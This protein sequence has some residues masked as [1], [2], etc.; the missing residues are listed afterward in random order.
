MIIMYRTKARLFR[1]FNW[2]VIFCFYFQTLWPTVVFAAEV[3]VMRPVSPSRFFY[4]P[5]APGTMVLEMGITVDERD[6][7]FDTTRKRSTLK[8]PYADTLEE[9]QGL[10]DASTSIQSLYPGLQVSEEGFGWNNFGFSFFLDNANHLWVSEQKGATA[11]SAILR[12]YNPHG[13]VIIEGKVNLT[14]LLAKGAQVFVK[15]CQGQIDHLSLWATD[16]DGIV[17][18]DATSS[19]TVKKATV[20]QGTLHNLGKVSV[21][22]N[23][24]LDAK[25][26]TIANYG[27]LDM[28]DKSTLRA[29]E[30]QNQRV[31]SNPAVSPIIGQLLG[32]GTVTL[33]IGTFR[34]LGDV[35]VGTLQGRIQQLINAGHF[36][37]IRGFNNLVVL[38]LLNDMGGRILGQ[39][40]LTLKGL[41]KGLIQGQ[42]ITLTLEGELINTEFGTI[43]VVDRLET[44]GTGSFLQRGRLDATHFTINN[45]RFENFAEWLQDQMSVVIGKNVT[46]WHNHEDAKLKAKQVVVESSSHAS[47]LL[48]EGNLEADEFTNHR[49]TFR[50][51][52]TL[53]FKRWHQFGHSFNN[54]KGGE[55]RVLESFQATMDTLDNEGDIHFD[56][57]S[58][59]D[60][61]HILNSGGLFF[62]GKTSLKGST[63]HNKKL[64]RAKQ[65]Q[66]FE[67][68][69]DIIENFSDLYL[70]NVNIKRH[71]TNAKT[72]SAQIVRL[73][74]DKLDELENKGVL[75]VTGDLM[76]EVE[77]IDSPGTLVV[78]GKTNIKGKNL[79]T[80]KDSIMSLKGGADLTFTD[81]LT[82]LG[83][84]QLEG[85][86]SLKAP[87]ITNK[88][89]LTHNRG[90]ATIEGTFYHEG[91]ALF[92]KD[93]LEALSVYIRPGGQ[94][95]L[96]EGTHRI[97][98]FVNEGLLQTLTKMKLS[99]ISTSYC[100]GGAIESE[101]GLRVLSL[102]AGQKAQSPE[103]DSPTINLENSPHAKSYHL[104]LTENVRVKGD[105][106]AEFP[107][108]FD[109]AQWWLII[110]S[111]K[112][113]GVL[114]LYGYSFQQ[115]KDITRGG[116]LKLFVKRYQNKKHTFTANALDIEADEFDVGTDNDTL[117]MIQTV[118]DPKIKGPQD[119]HLT[120]TK[121]GRSW[122]D[123]DLRFA[124]V[125]GNG[126]TSLKALAG[127]V[128]IGHYREARNP[129]EDFGGRIFGLLPRGDMT[130][131]T[132]DLLGYLKH[133]GAMYQRDCNADIE[134]RNAG[135]YFAALERFKR[136][137][138]ETFV[139]SNDKITIDAPAGDVILSY[140]NVEAKEELS[141]K[142]KNKVRQ[143]AGSIN[144]PKM[145]L[146][147]QSFE[148]VIDGLGF[149]PS[150]IF[151]SAFFPMSDQ[152]RLETN[153]LT[154][155]FQH[156]LTYGSESIIK[157]SFTYRGKDGRLVKLRPDAPI[158]SETFQELAADC[159]WYD[160]IELP[161]WAGHTYVPLRESIDKPW[162][163]EFKA[164]YYPMHPNNW[165]NF[166]IPSTRHTGK[167]STVVAKKQVSQGYASSG[168]IVMFGQQIFIVGSNGATLRTTPKSGV[169]STY[170]PIQDRIR[171]NGLYQTQADG[172]VRSP[173]FKD[174]AFI[175]PGQ[176]PVWGQSTLGVTPTYRIY[177]EANLVKSA[178]FKLM[179]VHMGRIH[180]EGLYGD[181]LIHNMTRYSQQHAVLG[182][183]TSEERL[184][185]NVSGLAVFYREVIIDGKP[186]AV[187]DFYLPESK[188]NAD[189]G[190]PGLSG[191]DADI[192]A[193]GVHLERVKV[194][195]DHDLNVT[196]TTKSITVAGSELSAG[197]DLT[198]DAEEWIDF[199]SLVQ[200][201][202]DGE[203]YTDHAVTAKAIAGHKLKMTTRQG[204]LRFKGAY[205]RSGVKTRFK[206]GRRIIDE[207]LALESQHVHRHARGWSKDTYTHQQQ[208]EHVTEGVLHSTAEETQELY[209]PKFRA[210]KVK[211]HGKHGVHFYEVHKLHRHESV[212]NSRSG[213]GFLGGSRKSE[214]VTSYNAESIG[215]EVDSLEPAE[216]T[217]GKEGITLTNVKFKTPKTVLTTIDGVVRFLLGTNYSSYTRVA[218]GSSL[219]WQSV[220]QQ[221]EEH[222]T[223]AS[224]SGTGPFEIYSKETIVQGVLGKTNEL[225]SQIEQHGGIV[226]QEMLAEYHRSESFRAGG[227]TAALAAVIA[228]AVTIA[229]QG[230]GTWLGGQVAGAA[231]LTT[232]TSLTTAGTFVA[233]ATTAAFTS[234]CSQAAI[235]VVA[236]KGDIGKA[237]NSLANSN[238]LKS[239]VM[240]AASG[241]LIDSI[242]SGLGIP[243]TAAECATLAD[244]A[245]R[246]V[247]QA[248]VSAGIGIAIGEDGDKVASSAFRGA[249][250]GTIG[251]KLANQ[252]GRAYGEGM[253]DAITHKL[254]HA[255]L[256][257]ATGSIL[258]SDITSGALS[259]AIGAVAAETV[260]DI[261]EEDSDVVVSKALEKAKAEGKPLDRESLTPFVLG[262]LRKTV[263]ISRFSGALATLLAGQDVAVGT[264]A[265]TIAVENNFLGNALKAAFKVLYKSAMKEAAKEGTK[266]GGR[267]ALKKPSTLKWSVSKH[268]VSR[269]IERNIPTSSIIDALK[270][271]LKVGPLKMDN[272]GRHSQRFIGKKA[273][274][275][276][277]P[278]TGKIVSVNRTGSQLVKKLLKEVE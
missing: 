262:E 42:S 2:L 1:S 189:A 267:A 248:S 85:D 114:S 192:V 256:G 147:G 266:Q 167:S 259:G 52:G 138:N 141:I 107:E 130:T 55:I 142:A 28:G 139:A 170:V 154:L 263:E 76:G 129:G 57:E 113:S 233:G 236:N 108:Y 124:K 15:G 220:S 7:A 269:K 36:E 50:N 33:D 17:A 63:I 12:L 88:G 60:I 200:R 128:V 171:N 90:K 265:G 84:V 3:D 222:K 119:N 137:R 5:S 22:E 62:N 122:E 61:L 95:T 221:L 143:V 241:G 271:P 105:F 116:A 64:I 96:G 252:I 32:S 35:R 166:S 178:L 188:V 44:L 176:E 152:P 109:I 194:R 234:L 150:P 210:R 213:G 46:H 275:A 131:E 204:D 238:T 86:L 39:G 132:L 224:T 24:T 82:F 212:S 277:N 98:T 115:D 249:L 6:E 243:T 87:E 45:A 54:L 43:K 237:A 268:G 110:S 274:V 173:Y 196:A 242:S 270:N 53:T 261:I 184:R 257:A 180:D 103:S 112:Q 71:F 245:A 227:P 177:A 118:A 175:P 37:A 193:D 8:I 182:S 244:H 226:T 97:G 145:T 68:T 164:I 205:T 254:M 70:R 251:G 264:A 156:Y 144:A 190:L 201:T 56:G 10:I 172:S 38:D 148:M 121:K 140:A 228:L 215:A 232:T 219:F 89:T 26:Q 92:E 162:S 49:Q 78:Q 169:H 133:S 40:S 91:K 73:L 13:S 161:C 69:G 206:S 123:L 59:G 66:E 181:D 258:S 199:E 218:Q 34:N 101:D 231:G 195:M 247:L 30:V 217:G 214:K 146:S 93:S 159:Y 135:I 153:N 149:M 75:C 216:I 100:R 65:G 134:V 273:T 203:N 272:L 16:K 99:V 111:W 209:A 191:I 58:S 179:A 11:R 239:I 160:C 197:H 20:H 250:A 104:L 157:E 19:L 120:L 23:G 198:L 223:Y 102:N 29:R 14:R 21:T 208:T 67:W 83:T 117:A 211:I 9:I 260:A 253:V 79:T 276:I 51:R 158:P 174:T 106:I 77:S 48:N 165:A 125:F 72:G 25:G 168:A 225:L 186:L 230:A 187:L 31:Q 94:L 246:A 18:I 202:G 47:P 185:K 240:A 80:A 136:T 155:L 229:T 183:F 278:E 151:S 127:N 163:A 27:F 126:E 235:A 41:N 81:P 74:L 207:S 4:A 255:A